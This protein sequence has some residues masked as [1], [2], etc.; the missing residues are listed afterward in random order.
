MSKHQHSQF[1]PPKQTHKNKQTQIQINLSQDDILNTLNKIETIQFHE[2]KDIGGVKFTPY[3]AGHVLGAA[4]FMMEIS[5]VKV[6]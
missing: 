5:G 6:I 4:M 3:H 1:K 2:T